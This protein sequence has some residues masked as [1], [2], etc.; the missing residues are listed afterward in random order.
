MKHKVIVWVPSRFPRIEY[1]NTECGLSEMTRQFTLAHSGLL[2][3]PVIS[4]AETIIY[5]GVHCEYICIKIICPQV[6]LLRLSSSCVSWIHAQLPY[7]SCLR[8]KKWVYTHI[9][10]RS[11]QATWFKTD[12]KYF[13]RTGNKYWRCVGAG[14]PQLNQM[15]EHRTIGLLTWFR[16]CEWGLWMHLTDAQC[17]WIEVV[18]RCTLVILTLTSFSSAVFRRRVNRRINSL[19]A[20]IQCHKDCF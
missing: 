1:V 19:K 9:K 13:T 8:I 15:Y 17:Q 2:R 20:D 4:A 11:C 18:L 5:T 7:L 3:N 10:P 12:L 14:L 6:P 16:R